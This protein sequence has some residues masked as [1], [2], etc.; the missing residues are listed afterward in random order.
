V[1]SPWLSNL[2]QC[3]RLGSIPGLGRSPRKGNDNSHQYSCLGNPTNRGD[4]Q[5]IVHGVAKELDTLSLT[6]ETRIYNRLKTISLTSGVG[7][8][9]QPLVKE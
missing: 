1:G 4:W 2:L 3:R 9:G 6:K 8:T 5:T 7:K